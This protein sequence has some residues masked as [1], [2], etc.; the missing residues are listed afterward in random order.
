M[1]EIHVGTSGWSYDDWKGVFYPEGCSGTKML[2]FYAQYFRTVELNASFYRLPKAA[3][4]EGWREKSP[5][6]F[7]F[8]VKASKFITHTK[9][10]FDVKEPWDAFIANA[11]L[12][13]DKLGPILFQLPPSLKADAAVLNDLF[14]ILPKEFLYVCEPRNESF[15]EAPVMD[16]FGRH[17][18]CLCVADSPRYPKSFV[19]TA[20]FVY[21]RLHGSTSLYGSKYTN[22]ELAFWANRIRDWRDGGLDVY[23]YFNN[24]FKGFAVDNAKTLMQMLNQL[25]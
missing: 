1:A 18:I 6:G 2:P 21:V 20:S 14:S 12:L 4:F 22:E 25:P 17:G 5:E 19:T 11:S 3:T 9:R 16:L 24:D 7:I 13:R 15:F 8:A 10:L 23:L